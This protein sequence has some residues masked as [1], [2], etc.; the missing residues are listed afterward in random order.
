M[1]LVPQGG[2]AFALVPSHHQYSVGCISLFLSLVL[3]VATSLRCASRVLEVFWA[4]WEQPGTA[5]AWRTGRWWVLRV[6]Y[7]KLTRPKEQA[8]DWVWIVDHTD[9]LGTHK[10]LLILGLRLSALPPRGQCLRH[11]DVEPLV[12]EP[13][14][15]STGELV[16]Q[17]L[18]ATVE[19]TGV[20]REIIS[21]QGGDVKAGVEQFRAAH[22]PTSAIYDIK[23][24]TAAILK[25]ELE[26][27]SAWQEFT[28][29]C[30]QTRQKVQQTAL[31][32]LRPPNQRAKARWMN[33]ELLVRWGTKT[34]VFL[35]TPPQQRSPGGDETLLEE[36]LGFRCFL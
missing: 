6:G 32:F 12:L 10:C 26:G 36:K 14:V 18:E 2:A 25:H 31:A 5:P 9:Q 35:D 33:V 29:L 4:I 24:K 22:P 7:Y 19:K 21:D 23:H 27:D 3:S 20:P 17:Q 16:Y 11:E 15:K 34:L 28:Q 13:V 8:E 30:H 1:A